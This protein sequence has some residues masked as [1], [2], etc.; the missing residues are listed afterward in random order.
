MQLLQDLE[1]D[2]AGE[3]RDGGQNESSD[4]YRKHGELRNKMIF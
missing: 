1:V 2:G 4:A 3:V